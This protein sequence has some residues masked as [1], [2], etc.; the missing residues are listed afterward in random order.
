MGM[1]GQPGSG[2]SHKLHGTRR[3]R[4]LCMCLRVLHVSGNGKV[5]GAVD[6]TC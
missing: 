6:Q 1:P 5:I 3:Y 2:E 4:L